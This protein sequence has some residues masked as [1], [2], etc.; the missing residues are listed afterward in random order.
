[1]DREHYSIL[2]LDES[3]FGALHYVQRHRFILALYHSCEDRFS[4]VVRVQFHHAR[5]HADVGLLRLMEPSTLSF[6]FGFRIP[7]YLVG[8]ERRY[9]P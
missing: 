2:L 5:S 9:S 7:A 4:Q 1:M 6:F 8:L 3:I